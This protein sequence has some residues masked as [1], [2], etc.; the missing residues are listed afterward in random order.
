[1]IARI[2]DDL[3]PRI[4]PRYFVALE[5]RVYIDDNPDEPESVRISDAAVLA[6]P[7]CATTNGPQSTS[8]AAAQGNGTRALVA[9]VPVPVPVRE[10]YLEVR[11]VATRRMVT[12][13]EVLSPTNKRAGRGR[14]QYLEKRVEVLGT[15]TNLVEIDLLRTGEPMPARIRDWP[16]EEPPP[17]D[18]RILIARG[19]RRPLADIYAF[20]LRDALPVFPVPLLPE[21]EEPLV[22]LQE[23]VHRLYDRA[24]YDLQLD[25]RQPPVIRL[26]PS[27][28]KWADHLLRERGLR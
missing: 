12:L 10:W 25:Y 2:H 5:E 15:R 27:D 8:L 17:G 24:S 23:L 7:D 19:S 3:S 22:N 1:L 14:T 20:T 28:E 4:R 21:D 11:H 9:T 13:I 16:P 26:T 18:Y 6:A